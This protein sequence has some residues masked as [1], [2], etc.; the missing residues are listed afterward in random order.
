ME[1]TKTQLVERICE[2]DSK[3]KEIR[4]RLYYKSR[5]EL[6]KLYERLRKHGIIDNNNVMA[7][8]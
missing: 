5:D 8:F 1:L 2:I 4:G 6:I 3:Y 7:R